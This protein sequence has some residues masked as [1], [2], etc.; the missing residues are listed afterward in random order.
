MLHLLDLQIFLDRFRSKRSDD[1]G[2][3]GFN[4]RVSDV[5]ALILPLVVLRRGQSAILHELEPRVHDLL[6]QTSVVCEVFFFE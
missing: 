2:V 1:A 6:G 3:H 4:E 5:S